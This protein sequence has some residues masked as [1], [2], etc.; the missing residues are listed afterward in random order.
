MVRPSIVRRPLTPW[1]LLGIVSA[2]QV[3]ASTLQIGLGFVLPYLKLELDLTNA[4]VAVLPAAFY[5]GVMLAAFP[6]GSSSDRVGE[7]AI[8]TGGMLVAGLF[9]LLAALQPT[10]LLVAV[11]LGIAGLGCAAAH[12]TGNRLVMRVFPVRRR[13]FALG[14]RQASVPLGGLL[15]AAMMAPLAE[16]FG[17]RVGLASSGCYLLAM[18]LLVFMLLPVDRQPSAA[19]RSIWAA[20]PSLLHNRD[21]CLSILLAMLMNVAQVAVN[22]FLPL[23]VVAGLQHDVGIAALMLAVVQASAIVGRLG[24]GV[25][26][27]RFFGGRRRAPLLLVEF[28]ALLAALGLAALPSGGHPALL[29]G[30][31]ALTGATIVGWNALAVALIAERAGYRLAGSAAGVNTASVYLIAVLV[32][33]LMGLLIDTTGTYRAAWLASGLALV[34]AAVTTACLRERT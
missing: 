5:A 22:T 18:A 12:P 33:P 1:A 9:T 34:G 27:D 25:I 31:A 19:G 20:L 4:Q 2:A 30:V 21:F 3:G 10:Y 15:A 6:A 7:R 32:P 11:M 24:S 14:V 17:W 26:S 28:A 13:G 23:F 29:I 8:L 16:A